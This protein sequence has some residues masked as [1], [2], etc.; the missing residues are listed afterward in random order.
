LLA[1]SSFFAVWKRVTTVITD[2]GGNWRKLTQGFPK[3]GVNTFVPEGKVRASLE[4]LLLYAVQ[5]Q[6]NVDARNIPEEAVEAIF[7]RAYQLLQ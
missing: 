1:E 4:E 6:L 7:P 5:Y 2:K 3:D